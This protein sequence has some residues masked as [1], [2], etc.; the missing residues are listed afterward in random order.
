MSLLFLFVVSAFAVNI[1]EAFRSALERNE[2]AHQAR[3][4]VVQAKERYDQAKSGPL[5]RIE[6][7]LQHT[8]QP[9]IKDPLG[10]AFA[11]ERQTASS[12]SLTQPIFSGFREFS[13]LRQQRELLEAQRKL[14]VLSLSQIYENVATA[15]LNVLSYEQDLRNLREQAEIS[16]ARVKDLLARTRRGES[17]ANEALTAQAEQAAV[18]AEIQLVESQL[19][20]ARENFHYLT[21]MPVDSKLDEIPTSTPKLAPLEEYL[22]RLERRPDVG[23]AALEAEAARQNVKVKRGSFWPTVEVVGNYYFERPGLL[24]EVDWDVTF[25]VKF[26]FFE[27]GLRYNEVQEAASMQRQADLEV[28]R[29]RR[30]ATAEIRGLHESLR[31]RVDQLKALERAAEM[32]RKSYQSLQREFR[33]G[34][35]RNIDVQLAQSDFRV[36]QRG[37]DQARYAARLDQIKLDLAAGRFPAEIEG[38]VK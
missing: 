32:S 16:A 24:G 13:G 14:E 19:R 11:P 36:K 29:L 33:R 10:R 12:V 20:M 8:I 18:D 26:P 23:A 2:A 5:P 27:G 4:Q 37:Y 21:G 31:R 3:E 25:N 9:R 17:R 6:Y 34:L 22:N 30:E 15:Y 38:R 28:S 1:D 35:T 7:N